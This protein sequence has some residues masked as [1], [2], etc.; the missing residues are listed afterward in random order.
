MFKPNDKVYFGRGPIEFV[1]E[2]LSASPGKVVIS[3]VE[4]G[5]LSLQRYTVEVEYVE[6]LH[7]IDESEFAQRTLNE[8][9]FADTMTKDRYLQ[10]QAELEGHE[11][12]IAKGQE[13]EET[14]F[15]IHEI[16]MLM[17][18]SPWML[19]P[20]DGCVPKTGKPQDTSPGM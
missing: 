6:N 4:T 18:N 11:L 7:V 20:D 15:R 1:G 12:S 3:G 14:D 9:A 17:D 10:L 5:C 8:P 2:V 19:C 16:K 13:T